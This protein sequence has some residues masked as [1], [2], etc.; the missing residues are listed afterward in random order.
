MIKCVQMSQKEIDAYKDAVWDYILEHCDITDNGSYFVKFHTKTRRDFEKHVYARY[1]YG[2]HRIDERSKF[3]NVQ[4]EKDAQAR[5][6][7]HMSRKTSKKRKYILSLKEQ[8]EAHERLRLERI[9]ND[10]IAKLS[11]LGRI[12]HNLSMIFMRPVAKKCYNLI[13]LCLNRQQKSQ[14]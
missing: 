6:Q 11:P 13:D 7:A 2:Y 8:K 14:R 9:E 12:I 4:K 1:K 5:R 3:D 10:R